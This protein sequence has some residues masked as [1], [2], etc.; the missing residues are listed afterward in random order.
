MQLCQ[1]LFVLLVVGLG[2]MGCIVRAEPVHRV[3]VY[4]PPPPP[5]VEVIPVAPDPFFVWVP[6]FYFHDHDSYRWHRGYYRH[7]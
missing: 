3:V 2:V 4:G 6:G 5:P 1:R 7:R